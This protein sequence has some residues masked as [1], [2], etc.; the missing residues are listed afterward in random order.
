MLTTVALGVVFAFMCGV[1]AALA[2][3]A[4]LNLANGLSRVI[5]LRVDRREDQMLAPKAMATIARATVARVLA[6]AHSTKLSQ[7]TTR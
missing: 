1:L 2:I 5:A 4:L 7:I 6:A 3:L